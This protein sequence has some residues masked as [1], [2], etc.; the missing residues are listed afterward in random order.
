M[1]SV[2]VVGSGVAG[3]TAALEADARGH[4]VTLLTKASLAAGSTARAQGGVAGASGPGDT[5]AAH[6]ADTLA[7]GA[8]LVDPAAAATLLADGPAA[9]DALAARGVRFDTDAEGRAARGL[10]AAHGVPRILHAGGD[11]TGAEIVRALGAAVRVSGVDVREDAFALDVVV[12]DGRAAGVRLLGGEVV[13]ADAVVLA[14]GGSG[15]LFAHTT[16]PAVATADG[17]AMALRAG[18]AVADLEMVQLHPTVLADG[19]LVSEAVRGAGAVLRDASGRR[20]LLDV[21][22]RGELAPRDVVARAVARRAREQGVPVVLDATALGPDVLAARFPTI[23]A[24][25]RRLGLDWSREPVPV[26]PAAHYAMGGVATD[27]DGRSS[28]PGLY[29]V[30][31][32][33]CT[34]LHGANRL[35]SNSLLEGAVQGRRV[36]RALEQGPR[37]VAP[38]RSWDAPEPVSL[39]GGTDAFSRADLQA[40]VWD[41]LGVERTGPALDRAAEQLDRWAAP[42]PGDPKSAEDAN[43]LLVA[44]ATVHAARRRTESRGAHQ[45]ADHPRTDPAQAR[46]RVLRREGA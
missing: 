24:T 3:L 35:A 20:F 21:D 14:T 2:V 1:T 43:L 33:A 8:G 17:V 12:R 10:E 25:V 22:P 40:L 13:E 41:A 30:G 45:R 9:V 19:F 37:A 39:D 28:V 11:A 16:N 32:T 36:V 23:D 4:A 27:A 29:A 46:H 6:L 34:G 7:A 18:A 26:T 15:Q 42:E 5:V 31:E 44:R 38:G